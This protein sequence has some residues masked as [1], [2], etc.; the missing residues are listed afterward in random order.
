[1]TVA[2]MATAIGV[3]FLLTEGPFTIVVLV[4]D[5]RVTYGKAQALVSPVG[6]TGEAWVH[7][8]RLQA[9]NL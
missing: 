1:M 4:Q 2:D 3:E 5:M 8:D 6:G 7:F 9:Y